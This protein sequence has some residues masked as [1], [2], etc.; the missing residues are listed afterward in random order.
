MGMLTRWLL[1]EYDAAG[2]LVWSRS[3]AS[4]NPAPNRVAGVAVLP[5]DALV[6]VG[7]NYVVGPMTDWRILRFSCP[8]PPTP[9]PPPA[10]PDAPGIPAPAAASLYVYPH[11][12][13]CPG[14]NAVVGMAQPGTL[15]LRIVSMRGQVVK[16]I[17]R[18]LAQSATAEVFLDC[19]SVGSGTY[20]LQGEIAYRDGTTVR[21]NP[22]KFVVAGTP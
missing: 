5:D 17:T 18:H 13:K 12:L 11:P 14:G 20:L 10:V 16:T 22:Y 3:V 1:R 4:T 2:N 8:P 9:V 6:A 21:L 19:N 7:G 15:T